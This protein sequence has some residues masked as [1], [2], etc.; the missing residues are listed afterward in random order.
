ML[1]L[2]LKP[3]CHF[4]EV[5]LSCKNVLLTKTPRPVLAHDSMLGRN[6]LLVITAEYPLSKDA[7]IVQVPNDLSYKGQIL[8]AQ[9]C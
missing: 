5:C 6:I 3:D 1:D 2:L 8:V 9:P 4:V 7:V